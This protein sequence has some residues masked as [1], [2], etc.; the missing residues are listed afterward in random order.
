MY[1]YIEKPIAYVVVVKKG[2]AYNPKKLSIGLFFVV[3]STKLGI[4]PPP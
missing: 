4:H 3:R 1:S 2:V